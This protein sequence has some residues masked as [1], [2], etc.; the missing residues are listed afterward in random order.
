MTAHD[1]V[2]CARKR[3]GI[4]RVG[5][6]GTLD[7]LAAGVL[8]VAV[9]AATRLLPYLAGGKEYLAEVA[10]GRT[11]TTGDAAGATIVEAP[12][13]VA[14]ADLQAVLPRF[15]GEVL[16]VPPA[17]SAVHVGGRRAYALARAGIAVEIPPRRVVISA[18]EIV[19]FGPGPV[20]LLRVACSAGTYI[21]SLAV[22]IGE[23]LAV[24]AYLSFLLR[25]RAGPFD[26]AGADLLS[27]PDWRLVG[28]GAALA[29]LPTI[30]VSDEEAERLRRGQPITARAGGAEVASRLSDA[31]TEACATDAAGETGLR[32]GRDAGARS[33]EPEACATDAAGVARAMRSDDLVA[34]V[35]GRDGA[36]WPR[37]V[38]P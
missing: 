2:A 13:D 30:A 37:T 11:T 31:G 16:Q 1:V 14:E 33:S 36:Y 9:G 19:R 3:L 25:T 4:K 32:A 20:V 10:F 12:A 23:A 15:R 22:D 5:H 24:P 38:M 28:P 18:L 17:V 21:R 26:I 34:I 6:A 8:P 7:P 29:N 35:V 27:D